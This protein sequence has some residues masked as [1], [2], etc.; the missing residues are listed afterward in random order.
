MAQK[1]IRT[2]DINERKSLLEYNST[3]FSQRKQCKLLGICRSG[4]YYKPTKVEDEN[5]LIM[6]AIDKEF[7]NHPYYG[8]RKMTLAM[9]KL[10]FEVGEKKVRSLM[11]LMGL[12][13]VYPKP[14]L[15]KANKEHK[16]YPYL[17]RNLTVKYPNQAWAADITYIPMKIGFGYLFAIIDWYS[18]Y[19]IEWDLS[20]LLDSAFCIEALDRSLQDT[21]PEIFNTDQGVQFRSNNFTQKLE[22]NGI[23]ISMDGKGR[24]IDNIFVERLWRSVKYE[25]I[26]LKSYETLK[27]VRQGLEEY[28]IFY[29]DKRPHQG[30]GYKTPAE[31]YFGT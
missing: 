10:G 30:I 27:D 1:K 24:A 4:L 19:V 26:Y 20:N 28:F 17:L 7:M 13:A 11:Q 18:R 31:A 12:E 6:N 14:S 2:I 25:D 3:I 23:K 16:K 21:K 22:N 5:V 9:K 15:S 8:R 29:N